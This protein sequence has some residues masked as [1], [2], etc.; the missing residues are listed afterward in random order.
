MFNN[1]K[2]F[3]D[4]IKLFRSQRGWNQELLADKAGLSQSEISKIEGGKV[5]GERETIQKLA[6]A[7]EVQPEVLVRNT[8]LA[9]LFKQS[10]L[11]FFGVNK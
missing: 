11:L 10:P 5:K 6:S 2:I 7:L 3:G 9:N 1:D 4:K 8:S